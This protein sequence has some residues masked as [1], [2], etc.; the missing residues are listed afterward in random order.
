MRG[1]GPENIL[2]M[3]YLTK[4]PRIPSYICYPLSSTLLPSLLLLLLL[5]FTWLLFLS[6]SLQ[7]WRGSTSVKTTTY[8]SEA[9]ATFCPYPTATPSPVF[10]LCPLIQGA[11]EACSHQSGP[12]LLQ[13]LVQ[14]YRRHNLPWLS[15][16][17]LSLLMPA[18]SSKPR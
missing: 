5:L 16:I 13:L 8:W 15:A 14:G 7:L 12:P 2:H 4:S 1:D 17:P 10:P 3:T 9:V 18:C 6:L 11:V